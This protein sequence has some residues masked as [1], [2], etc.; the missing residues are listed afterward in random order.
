MNCPTRDPEPTGNPFFNQNPPALDKTLTTRS[1]LVCGGGSLSDDE[2][3]LGLHIMALFLVLAQSSFACAF[4]LIAKKFPR[5]RIP[6]SFLFG[7]HH[8]GTGVLIATAFVHLLPTAFISLTDQC[9]PGFWNSTY[10]AMA[11][12]IAMVAVFFVTIVEMVFTKGLCKGGCSDTNQRD[13][14]CEAGDSYCNARDADEEYGGADKTGQKRC[15]GERLGTPGSEEIGGK[16]GVGRMGFGM[17]GKRRSRSH[18]VG[19]RLQKYE[20]MEKKGRQDQ[21]LPGVAQLTPEQ[22][23]KKALLQCVLLEMGILFHSVFIGMALSVTIGPGFVILL[24]AIIF[25]Q[26]FEGLAL[27]SRIAVLNWKADAVQ[28]WL[29]AV[30]YGLTTPV[31]QAIGLATHTLYSPSS[32]TGLLMVGIM[33]AISSGLLVFAGLVELLAED[34]LSDE[35]WLVLTGRKRIIACIYVMAG[36]FGMAFVGAFA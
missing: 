34:F 8:F 11:G 26:T 25:H 10:P 36:A 21:T 5:L 22:I 29:M 27:G 17:A 33:N 20:E 35:S 14:R 28:P 1:S 18:S 16:G 2:Y 24:I 19:Q 15:D 32:Q 3:N 7:A 13:V 23:H 6:P 9:L 12:A 30:A 4:P 31:G